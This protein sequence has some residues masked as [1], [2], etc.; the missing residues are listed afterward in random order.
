MEDSVVHWSGQLFLQDVFISQVHGDRAVCLPSELHIRTKIAARE[1]LCV[2]QSMPCSCKKEQL[3][4]VR[5]VQPSRQ[6]E[7]LKKYLTEKNAAGIVHCDQL[8]SAVYLLPSSSTVCQ[9]LELKN[10][11]KDAIICALCPIM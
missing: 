8:Y 1:V 2:M 6:F 10:N 5:P 4:I 11:C 7:K 9:A 3:L